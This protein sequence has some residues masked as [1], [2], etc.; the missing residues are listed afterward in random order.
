VDH[1]GIPTAFIINKEG[2]IAWMGHPVGLNEKLLNDILSDHYDLAKAAVEYEKQQAEEQKFQ[3][4]QDKLFSAIKQKKWD[5]ADAAADELEKML[6]KSARDRF[7]TVRLQILFGRKDYDGAY[8][9]AESLSDAHPDNAGLQNSLAWIIAAQA[10][11]EKRNLA[12]AEKMAERANTA[13]QAKEPAILDT[14]ARV[15]F[16]NGKTN[17][18][19]VTE[20]KAIN[21]A[22]DEAK[23]F[24]KKFLT[25]YQQGKLPEIKE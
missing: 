23:N 1:H 11:L 2:R 16:M 19:V 10:G 15:Q 24:Y 22:P 7:G 6:P 13:T 25:D 17:E 8:K 20:Q 14:L 12:L 3:D 5:A 4:E 21:T 18:A 9:L